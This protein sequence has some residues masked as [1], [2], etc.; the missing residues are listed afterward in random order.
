MIK[1]LTLAT[2]ASILSLTQC[3]PTGSPVQ[4]V[5][6]S[7]P[8]TMALVGG[9]VWTGEEFQSRDVFVSGDRFIAETR[10]ETCEQVF[11]DTGRFIAPPFAEGH[12]HNV[13]AGW[14]FEGLN[15]RYLAEGVYY[16]L[17][18]LNMPLPAQ[19]LRPLIEARDTIDV[20]FAH[21]ALT[22]YRGHPES[23]Y[24]ISLAPILYGNAPRESFV[25]QAFHTVEQ[26]ADI[27]PALDTLVEQGAD[28]VKIVL[29]NSENH[30]A[31]NAFLRDD[32][33]WQSIVDIATDE[34]R[35]AEER[36]DALMQAAV[37][38]DPA[39]VPQIV[40]SIHARGL[41]VVAHV[42]TANDFDVAVRAGVDTIVHMPGAYIGADYTAEMGA[43]SQASIELAAEQGIGV[44]A[45]AGV[46]PSFTAEEDRPTLHA[47]QSDNI[48]RL[49][50]AGVP[51]YIGTDRWQAMASEE[52]RYLI[53]IGAMSPP[54][55]FTAWI[56]T[57]RFIFPDRQI[58]RIEP[59]FEADVLVFASDPSVSFEAMGG[60]ERRMK[61]GSWL[62]ISE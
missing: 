59:G 1:L 22:S 2:A 32:A 5:A 21:G 37:G 12:S 24:V 15:Q 3:T 56:E 6:A 11:D 28:V 19:S 13:E 38:L 54:E 8:C 61:A 53:E 55:A 18:P 29:S 62:S 14:S 57:S 10:V 39:L 60:I 41:S 34:N 33:N 48:R 47:L 52:V 49:M 9:Q 4:E 30:A 17:N 40:E 20:A 43:I 46:R 35:S 45:T 25:G 26:A 23:V 51:V 31:R 50:D 44:V 42:N 36:L 58:G 27:N 16:V 7:G